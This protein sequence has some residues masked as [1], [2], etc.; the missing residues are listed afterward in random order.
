[1]TVVQFT[2]TALNELQG[3]A[4]WYEQRNRALSERF[5]AAATETADR[6][7]ANPLAHQIVLDGQVRR[8]NFPRRWPWALYY[9]IQP[10]KSIVIG[11]LHARMHLR[12]LHGRSP[13]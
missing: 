8:A 1:M 2:R 7:A 13:W 4:E 12:Q 5:L 9:V 11:A 10:D 3:A 6:I